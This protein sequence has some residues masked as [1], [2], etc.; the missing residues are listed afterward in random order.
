MSLP[1]ITIEEQIGPAPLLFQVQTYKWVVVARSDSDRVSVVGIEEAAGQF[2]WV[3]DVRIDTMRLVPMSEEDIT[4]L[5]TQI[6]V[7]L[8]R[9]GAVYS[10]GSLVNQV[11]AKA[12]ITARLISA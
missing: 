3:Y 9:P 6:A 12:N 8:S 7:A 2:V 10:P 5:T 4:L 11:I 1:V